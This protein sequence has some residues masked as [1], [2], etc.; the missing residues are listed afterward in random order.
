MSCGL[1]RE[2]MPVA[3]FVDPGVCAL[4]SGRVESFE[5]FNDRPEALLF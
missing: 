2:G 3:A 4:S 1:G 5:E